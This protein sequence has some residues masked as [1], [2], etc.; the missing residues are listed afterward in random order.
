M[1][2][3]EELRSML[4][5]KARRDVLTTLKMVGP[6]AFP[7]EELSL[8]LPTAERRNL[9]RDL[10]YLI[11]KHMVVCTNTRP[12]QAWNKKEF[13]L[14]AVGIETADRINRDPALFS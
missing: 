5:K 11:K 4:I 6:G 9:I 14:T 10:D 8:A 13:E 12:N 2:S 1:L 7:F 3:R